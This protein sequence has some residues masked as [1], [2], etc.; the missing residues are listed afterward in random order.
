MSK[1]PPKKRGRKLQL[2][3]E[4]IEKL[5]KIIS[6]TGLC[7]R[8]YEVCG[9]SQATF[10]KWI[11]D[12]PEFSEKVENAKKDFQQKNVD[13]YSHNKELA[14]SFITQVLAGKYYKKK[15]RQVL[16]RNDQIVTLEDEEQVV[17]G[18]YIL[19]RVFGKTNTESQTTFVF[20]IGDPT[21]IEDR[22]DGDETEILNLLELD[23]ED[24]I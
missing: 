5:C 6:E 9:F 15:R 1:E 24:D 10:Y 19:E 23:A 14:E 20:Q 8:A 21:P 13:E 3:P 12:Y 7:K 4:L 16:N 22:K 18:E 11:I 2:T 17:P